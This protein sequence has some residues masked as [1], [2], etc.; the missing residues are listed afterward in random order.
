MPLSILYSDHVA[1]LIDHP[2]NCDVDLD[3]FTEVLTCYAFLTDV[4]VFADLIRLLI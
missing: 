3:C 2:L 4:P 1:D